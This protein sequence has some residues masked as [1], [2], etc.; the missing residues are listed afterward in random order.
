MGEAHHDGSTSAAEL[1]RVS[2]IINTDGRA[3]SLASTLESLRQLDYEN[4]EVCVVYG[5]T[6]DGTRE[7][8]EAWSDRIKVARCPT[9]NLSRSRN[10][11]LALSSGEIVAFLDDD[12]IP[13]PEWLNQVVEP[14]RAPQVAVAGGFLLDH[15]GVTFQWKYGTADRLGRAN[16]DWERP[17]PEFNFPFSANYPHVIGANSVFRRSALLEIGGFDENFAYYLDETDVILRIIDIGG[18]V[19]QV[20]GARVHHKFRASHIRSEQ[21]ILKSW[22][23]IFYSKIY[24]CLVNSQNYHSMREI[25]DEINRFIDGFRRDLNWA[26]GAQ[27]IDSSY[28]KVFDEETE[29]AWRDGLKN[30]STN[31]RLFLTDEVLSNF[32][33][34][35]QHFRTALAHRSKRV[36][37][38]LSQS[39]PP[40]LVGGVGRYIHQLA[41]IIAS[42][43]HKVHVL[44]RAETHPTVDLEEG[45][46]VHRVLSE[47]QPREGSPI[48]LRIPQRIWDHAASACKELESIAAL[49]P[50]DVV[51]APIWD[52]EG[53]AA[54]LSQKFVVVTALQTTL[55]FWLDSHK[56]MLDNHEFMDDFATPMIDVERTLFEGSAGIHAISAAIAREIEEAYA[57]DFSKTHMAVVPLGQEDWSTLPVHMPEP[58]PANGIRVLFVGRLE[59]RKG[60]DVFLQILPA[61]LA[62]YPDLHVDIVGNDRLPNGFGGTY[63]GDFEERH[64]GAPFLDRVRFQGEV[65]E[66]ALRGFYKA[67]DVFVAPSRFES[68]GL[69]LLEA[70]MF[71]KP[72]I[73]C[74]AGGMVEVVEEGVSGL[75]ALPGDPST[76]ADALVALIG[77]PELRSR[78]GRAGRERY[79]ARFTPERMAEDV[80]SFITDVADQA[81]LRRRHG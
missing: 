62:Q 47:Y 19:A 69:I 20:E 71:G 54:L 32:A 25:I 72:V 24:F 59:E 13:E 43:G 14:F 41:R 22:Y 70:M 51:Y 38:L 49:R 28:Y 60:I 31:S 80:M 81:E 66:I 50:I 56:H 37:C 33:G 63:R 78:M 11:G 7:L 58:L 36:I 76:L 10:I 15:T 48:S 2:I 64:A 1:P 3:K 73:A 6:E 9:R 21:K 40:Q 61:L 55:K 8:A 34:Q 27:L 23:A 30:G 12:A 45:V 46:W 57:V 4:F 75:L 26:V 44:T 79:E 35:F 52:C 29:R 16:L 18:H 5:P 68:F 77:S 17:A 74:R 42:L 67:C 53:I 39:Y 65:Q